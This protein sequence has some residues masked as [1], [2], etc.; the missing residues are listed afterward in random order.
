MDGVDQ[1]PKG[2]VGERGDQV[3]VDDLVGGAVRVVS[4]HQGHPVVLAGDADE[5]EQVEHAVV[6]PA[7]CARGV[8]VR[9]RARAVTKDENQPPNS[10]A[11]LAASQEQSISSRTV[12]ARVMVNLRRDNHFRLQ[13]LQKQ[14]TSSRGA[15]LLP[16]SPDTRQKGLQKSPKPRSNPPAVR[17]KSA[18]KRRV[19][20]LRESRNARDSAGIRA[21]FR[22]RRDKV[23][24]N[25]LMLFLRGESVQSR[26]EKE[27]KGRAYPQREERVSPPPPRRAEGPA[28]RARV[29]VLSLQE[30]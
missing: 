10:P 20:V 14:K 17:F 19:L 12:P 16:R 15:H 11:T 23:H 9:E 18:W 24:L 30:L 26:R 29:R 22:R 27:E 3:R 25:S 6:V 13:L 28:P 5:L 1:V 21:P 8:S 7:L 2:A 4:L